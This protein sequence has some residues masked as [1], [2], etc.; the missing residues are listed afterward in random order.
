MRI[1]KWMH[2]NGYSA[3]DLSSTPTLGPRFVSFAR[4]AGAANRLDLIV[5]HDGGTDI[6]VPSN[7]QLDTYAVNDNGA[8]RKVTA[9]ARQDANTVRVTLDGNLSAAGPVTVDYGKDLWFFDEASGQHP[10]GTITDNRHTLPWPVSDGEVSA[11]RMNL[12]RLRTPL[13]EGQS[14]GTSG[15]TGT[16]APAPVARSLRFEPH[17][18]GRRSA[19]VWNTVLVATG[20]ARIAWV[21]QNGENGGWSW[22]GNATE[23]AVP[24]DG[25]VPIPANLTATGQFVVGMDAA[26]YNFNW[27]SGQ[28]TIA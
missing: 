17:E 19:G 15:G 25:R 21:V 16:T 8:G 9:A 12:Q 23:V 22:T 28:V 2:G 3:R 13:T 11:I 20:I 1:A 24:A 27:L 26:D 10:G 14:S 4:V 18:P 6:A 7:T 5:G